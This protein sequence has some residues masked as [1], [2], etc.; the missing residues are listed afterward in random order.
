VEIRIGKLNTGMGVGRDVPEGGSIYVG[1]Y[2]YTCMHIH[3]YG[4]FS[5]FICMYLYIHICFNFV[6]YLKNFKLKL[7]FSQ[8]S[9]IEP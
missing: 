7:L 4:I 2:V 1:L 5:N 8:F 3:T 6:F 9:M